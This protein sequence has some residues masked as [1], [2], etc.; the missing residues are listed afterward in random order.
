MFSFFQGKMLAEFQSTY[1]AIDLIDK[2]NVWQKYIY[3]SKELE[4]IDTVLDCSFLCKNVER[5][6]NCDLFAFENQICYL[7]KS[8]FADGSVELDL[9]NITIYL[10]EGKEI[11]ESSP[12]LFCMYL[13]WVF[14]L[15]PQ[16]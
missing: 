4:D 3:Q 12:F 15:A 10:T 1:H 8:S 7:G 5:K 6:N 16:S 2:K 9:I 13:P 14:Y 11:L